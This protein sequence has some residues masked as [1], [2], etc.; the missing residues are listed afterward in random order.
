MPVDA[1]LAATNAP[2]GWGWLALS[3]QGDYMNF[4]GIAFLA[5]ITMACYARIVPVLLAAG[6]RLY[7]AVAI[8][9][10]GILAASASGLIGAGR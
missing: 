4:I 1:Y 3:A 6:D 2:T 7:A 5:S 10:L 8:A 9:E